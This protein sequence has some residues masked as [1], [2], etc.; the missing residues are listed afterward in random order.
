M[1]D[2]SSGETPSRLYEIYPVPG[3][4]RGYREIFV[5]PVKQYVKAIGNDPMDVNDD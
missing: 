5:P 3:V 4:A 2:N 1:T